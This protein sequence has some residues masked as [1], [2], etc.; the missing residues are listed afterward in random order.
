[1]SKCSKQAVFH[2]GGLMSQIASAVGSDR[3]I[4]TVIIDTEEE[5]DWSDGFSRA[6]QSVASMKNIY[7]V[8]SI[9]EEFGICPV[10]AI[11]YPIVAQADGYEPL[12]TIFNEGRCIIGA[13]LHPWVSP[14]FSEVVNRENSFPGNLPEEIEEAKLVVLT[15]A[16]EE[17]FGMRP[18]IYKA[19][20]YGIGP[21]SFRILSRLGYK[22]DMSICPC[23][24]FS[25]EGGPD[26]SRW[27]AW[28]MWVGE[29]RD[30][31]ELPLTVGYSG[32][33]RRW[34]HSL[35]R[36][37]TGSGMR[38]LHLFGAMAR[39]GLLGKH[40]LSPEGYSAVDHI[41]L[42]QDLYRD[43]LRIFSLSFHSPSVEP[44][45][46]PF[47]RT[48][49]DLDDFLRSLRAFLSYFMGEFN[50]VARSPLE[51]WEA[52]SSDRNKQGEVIPC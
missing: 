14:P 22:I 30:I 29:Q 36:V 50:G 12:Q 25:H 35:F 11:D 21:N 19:G 37:T 10:Y 4:L 31:L 24:D 17:R 51:V 46:T 20:R 5:F 34:G 23:T 7:R 1:M 33:L 13:H 27:V 39:I 18:S 43:G 44:G 41:R 47:V 49:R 3:P 15:N 6:N 8:Q 28:P 45:H 32:F 16:I 48:S 9:F 40:W 52:L 42:V 26:F 2:G 38:Y